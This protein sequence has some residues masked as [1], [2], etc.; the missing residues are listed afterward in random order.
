MKKQHGK[1]R[2]VI[3]IILIII[4]AVTVVDNGRRLFNEIKHTVT[5]HDWSM[6]VL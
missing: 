5:H 3:V 2:K 6:T 4:G 1:F